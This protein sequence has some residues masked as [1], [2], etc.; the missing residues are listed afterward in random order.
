M[1]CAIASTFIFVQHVSSSSH[2]SGD[3]LSFA[4]FAA[5]PVELANDGVDASADE[6]SSRAALDIR[7]ELSG[8]KLVLKS[9]EYTPV[10]RSNQLS[11]MMGELESKDHQLMLK[12]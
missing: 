12:D 3:T 11:R 9:R 8:L 1:I 10:E 6:V 4:A 7:T 2:S 5:H